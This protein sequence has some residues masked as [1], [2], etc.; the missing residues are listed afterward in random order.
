[1]TGF[2]ATA[3]V[4]AVSTPSP[5]EFVRP[6][7]TDAADAAEA[8]APLADSLRKRLEEYGEIEQLPDGAVLYRAGHDPQELFLVISGGVDIVGYPAHGDPDTVVRYSPGSVVGELAL[9][10]GQTSFVTARTR[11]DSVVRRIGASEFRRIMA[12]EAELSDALLRI[13]IAR[14]GV[15]RT[16]VVA[17]TIEIIGDSHSRES[18]QLRTYAARQGIPHIWV[19]ANT[20][21]GEARLRDTGSTTAALPLVSSPKAVFAR[22]TPGDLAEVLGLAYPVGARNVD[23]VVIGAGPAGMA[24]AVYGASEGLETVVLDAVA[25]GGQ[26]AASSRI[27]NYLGFPSGISG[28]E[29]LER[30]ALQAEKFGAQIYTPCA[31]TRLDT[32]SGALTLELSDG[33]TIVPRAAIIATGARYRALPLNRWSEFEE[34]SIYYAATDLEV[35]EC[36]TR[37]VV[38]VGGANS[39]GQAALHL[40]AAGSAVT[41]VIRSTLGKDMS[42]YLADRLSAHPGITVRAGSQVTELHGDATLRAVTVTGPDGERTEVPCSGLFCFAGAEPA[43]GWLTSV[44]TDDDGFVLTDTDLGGIASSGAVAEVWAGLGRSPLPFETSVP[45]LFAV[46]DVRRGSMKRVAAAVGEGASAVH[47][48]HRAL[49][50]AH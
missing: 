22:A 16:G 41:V 15:L 27:E 31:V 26:A 44:V 12:T 45:T 30:S 14:R 17:R 40:A 49:G 36:E 23:L 6:E 48:V 13:L 28:A 50:H 4:R 39:A 1:M 2:P 20:P 5:A 7:G 24:A 32:A 3:S 11:G 46:G 42:S 21:A 34:T 37:P 19:E 43:T 35:R 25:V 8:F 38:V 47:S 29:L 18:L 33:T 10:T 9:L